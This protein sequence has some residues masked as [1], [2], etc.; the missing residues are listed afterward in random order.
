LAAARS[1][2]QFARKGRMVPE[3]GA[4]EIRELI[5]QKRYRVIYRVH[6]ERN[7]IDVLTVHHGKLPVDI[8]ALLDD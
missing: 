3:I 6:D 4:D 5:V 1:L 8:D 2:E 7:A